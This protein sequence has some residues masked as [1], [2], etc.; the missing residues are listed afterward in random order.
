MW[1]MVA[2]YSELPDWPRAMRA[3]MAAAYLGISEWTLRKGARS[4]RYPKPLK[5]GE[6][7]VWLR[8]D[9]DRWLDNLKG[10]QPNSNAQGQD[11]IAA[12]EGVDV[13]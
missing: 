8:E 9:L 2:T 4:G 12:L 6:V 7:V 3:P 13:G 10:D 11:P 1:A 5:D